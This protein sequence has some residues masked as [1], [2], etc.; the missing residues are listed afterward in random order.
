M[1]INTNLY[2]EWDGPLQYRD[3][4]D[5]EEFTMMLPTDISLLKDPSYRYYVNLYAESNDV[6]MK[7]FGEAFGKLLSL[8]VPM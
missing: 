5:L 7:D 4:S 2:Q 6:W 8:G 3:K 1:V